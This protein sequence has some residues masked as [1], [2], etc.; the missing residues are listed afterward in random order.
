MTTNIWDRII[1]YSVIAVVMYTSVLGLAYYSYIKY[2]RASRG[3]I[4][5]IQTIVAEIAILINNREEDNMYK[6]ENNMYKEEK[7]TVKHEDGGKHEK[8]MELNNK[9]TLT[10]LLNQKATE[11]NYEEVM[12][13]LA[14]LAQKTYKEYKFLIAKSQDETEQAHFLQIVS[15]WAENPE[16]HQLVFSKAMD[17]GIDTPTLQSKFAEKVAKGEV[18]DL[19]EEIT[20]I[21]NDGTIQPPTGVSPINSG[22]EGGEIAFII[23]FIH[24]ENLEAWKKNNGLLKEEEGKGA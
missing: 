19:G 16:I 7:L 4:Q 21:T 1:L 14:K 23:S 15:N 13:I 12:D 8:T 11:E 20:V 2:E 17:Y 9:L 24:K 3:Y 18:L 10:D 6:E 22:I 5:K